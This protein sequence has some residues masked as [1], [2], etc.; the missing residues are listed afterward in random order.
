MTHYIQNEDF[1]CFFF[2]SFKNIEIGKWPKCC[3]EIWANV[4][5]HHPTQT[6]PEFNH[7]FY[8]PS[9]K[10]RVR[11]DLESLKLIENEQWRTRPIEA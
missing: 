4:R 6:F 8:Y 1:L 11:V 7:N 9:K 2:T 5:T 3:Y 10:I